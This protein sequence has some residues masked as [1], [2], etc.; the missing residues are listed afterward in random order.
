M[1]EIRTFL[2][3]N[4]GEVVILFVEPYVR[5]AAIADT[6]A[7]AGLERSLVTLDRD[8]P[9]PTLATLPWYLD[10]FSFVQDTPLGATKVG[11]L[12]CKLERGDADSPIL[13]LNHGG[14]LV[15]AVRIL[16]QERIEALPPQ[17]AT[18]TRGEA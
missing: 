12:S 13:M 17:A 18:A 4:P 1:P 3:A 14:G 9:L 15:D 6:F 7:Q 10:G 16:N 11:Q 5:P 8:E 2:D